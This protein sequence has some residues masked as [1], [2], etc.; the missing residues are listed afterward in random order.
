MRRSTTAQTRPTPQVTVEAVLYC[1][2]Q[3]GL[4]ALDEPANLAR[5]L[6]FDDAAFEQLNARIERLGTLVHG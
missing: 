3:R 6:T 2:Q 5:L 4:C 1:V